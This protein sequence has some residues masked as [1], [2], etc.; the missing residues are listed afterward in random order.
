MWN[1]KRLR[2]LYIESIR[3]SMKTIFTLLCSFYVLNTVAQQIPMLVGTYTQHGSQGI[4][5]YTFH[6]GTAEAELL[7]ATTTTNP[8]FLAKSKNNKT[9]YAVNETG[10]NEAS[11]SAFAFDGETLS[12]L[13]AIPSNG[14]YPCHVSVS[15]KHA[16]A[17]VANYGGGSLAVYNLEKNGALGSLVQ[18]IQH[19]GSGQNKDRQASSHVH[20]AFFSPD[21]QRVYVQ[22]LG[23]DQITIYRVRKSGPDFVLVEEQTINTPAG[24]G[25]R[26][27]VIDK[28]EKNLYVLLELTGEVA[29]F[30]KKGKDWIFMQ[31]VSMNEENFNGANGAAEIK[32]SADGKHIYASNRGDANTITLFAVDKSGSMLKKAVYSTKGKGPRNFNLSPDG[33]HVLVANQQSNNIVIFERNVQTGELIDMDKE[34]QVPTPV[35]VL[36]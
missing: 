28:K 9:V 5:L 13:N 35:C 6:L 30:Q 21:F 20:S 29:H 36:F 7:S 23:A 11:L 22:D 8:S 17:I 18:H 31:S 10:D 2:N 27:V 1:C 25:P 12:F 26:H 34:I 15:E 4:Y 33:K 32:M 24:G 3:K 14:A 16:L 19:K